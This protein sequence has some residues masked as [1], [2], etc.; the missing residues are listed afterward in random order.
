MEKM[1]QANNS[2]KKPTSQPL[3][4]TSARL[5]AVHVRSANK[6]IFKALL[7]LASAN[8]LLRFMGLGM[9]IIVVSHFALGVEM[10][11][12]T[13]AYLLTTTLAMMLGSALEA[14]VIPVYARTRVRGKEQASRLFS[15]LLNIL[16]IGTGLLA[17]VL[18]LFRQQAL[19]LVA[20]GHAGTHTEQIA[21]SLTPYLI[22]VFF[23]MTINSFLECLLNAEGQFGWPAYAG[24]AVPISTAIALLIGGKSVGVLMLCLGNLIGLVVQLIIILIRAH[25]AQLR[26]KPVLELNSPDVRAIAAL[27]IAPLGA[28][29]IGQLA[30]LLDNSFIST[31]GETGNVAAMSY[32][33]KLNGVFTGVIFASVGK[34][35]LPY[36][37]SQAAIKDMKAFK[38]TLRLYLWALGIVTVVLAIG[39]SLFGELAVRILFQHGAFTHDDTVRTAT[40]LFGLMLGLPPTALAFL[41][42]RA[43]SALKK[44]RVLMVMTIINVILNAAFDYTFKIFWGAFGIALA[45]SAYYF[46]SMIILLVTLRIQIGK[47][48]LLKPPPE[49]LQL[50]GKSFQAWISWRDENL[51]SPIFT[52]AVKKTLARA[53]AVMTVLTA[54]AVGAIVNAV[55]TL[56]IAFGSIAIVAMLR[57]PYLLLLAWIGI[58]A[59]IGSTVPFLSMFQGGNLLSGLTLPTLLLMF[60]FPIKSTFK[61]MPTLAF[62]F[63][64][65]LWVL[66][67]VGWSEIGIQQFMIQWPVYM[68]FVAVA[69]MVINLATTKRLLNGLIDAILVQSTF[70][71]LFGIFDWLPGQRTTGFFD[72]NI[73]TLYRVGSVF[74]AP[75]TL[76]FFLTVVFPIS[77]YRVVTVK[78]FWGRILAFIAM[79]TILVAF[80]LTF[81]R[82]PSIAFVLGIIGMIFFLPSRQ[83]R[84]GMLGGIGVFAALGA[85]A[86]LALNIPILDRFANNDLTTLNGRTL[87]WDAVLSHVN[88]LHVM[89]EGLNASDVLLTKLQ[90]G[91]GRGVVGTAP[92]NIFIGTLYDQGIGGE[93]LVVLLLIAIPWNLIKKMLRTSAQHRLL[94]A[95]VLASYINMAVQS[96]EVTVM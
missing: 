84:L 5:I 44:T 47:L 30:P 15:T 61:R 82:G 91:F 65:L 78:N 37:A 95:A 35:A 10:D 19:F 3:G 12:Y 90:V 59:V 69:V 29:L 81:S 31:V 40:L 1:L 52:Y 73:S 74:S 85:I 16:I 53:V 66:P 89:G 55:L 92:H 7:S 20:P 42:S 50:V 83:M 49:L 22:P 45:T 17:L 9:Q 77:L 26:Y 80:V 60:F 43:F 48:D 68:S 27:A 56:R 32:A 46:C 25:K 24:A 71:S 8:L 33:N 96:L 58:D 28:A 70:I 64:F 23:L 62:L 36:L 38:N 51:S 4:N 72:T 41:T 63:V 2:S 76:A 6:N 67:S 57:Y 21:I 87:L 75:P 13:D 34:A 18:F 79:F 54:G 11:A 86:I 39:M 94:L 93:V 14:S 88:L